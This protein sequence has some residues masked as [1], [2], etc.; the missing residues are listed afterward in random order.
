M[1]RELLLSFR[2]TSAQNRAAAQCTMC[3]GLGLQRRMAIW[4]NAPGTIVSC[5]EGV[6]VPSEPW[7]LGQAAEG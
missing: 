5:W 1:K 7:E 4:L 3:R 2:K 6:G